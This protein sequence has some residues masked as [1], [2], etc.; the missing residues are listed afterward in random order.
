MS[1]D[2]ADHADLRAQ[3][4]LKARLPRTWPAFF[5]RYGSFTAAQMAAIPPLLAGEGLLLCA[6]TASGKTAAVLAPLV[7]R[8]CP[9]VRPPK[10]LRI[11]YLTPTRA[12]VNDL[13]SRLAHPL[14]SIG[15]GLG[16]KTS[17]GAFAKGRPPDVLI[18]TPES[19]DALLAADARLFARLRAVVI[20]ELHLFDGTPRGDQLRALLARLRRVRA[21]AA[22]SGDAPDDTL[23][24]VALSATI[25]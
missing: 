12:L 18:T 1:L 23:Q 6:P 5:E 10:Q 15:V 13:R 16:V 4:A 9:P 7:E 20:D 21:Y 22:A 3:L 2:Q 14:A 8:Y 24:C 19:L 25:A 17:D 11:L